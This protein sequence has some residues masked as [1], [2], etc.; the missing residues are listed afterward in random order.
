MTRK[1]QDG[2][3]SKVDIDNIIEG[4]DIADATKHKLTLFGRGFDTLDM[5]PVEIELKDYTKLYTGRFH[6]LQTAC[7]NMAK[8]EVYCLCTGNVSE[9]I[10]HTKDSL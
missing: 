9:K 4:L 7:E 3:Y 5:K 2:D 10:S 6:K 8:T 1:I